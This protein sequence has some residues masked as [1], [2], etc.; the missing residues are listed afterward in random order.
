MRSNS[1]VS[2]CA[3]MSLGISCL[4]P[5]QWTGDSQQCGLCEEQLMLTQAF[6]CVPPR[7]RGAEA[8]L[9]DLQTVQGEGGGNGLRDVQVVFLLRR[10]K[11][12]V[13]NSRRRCL[14]EGRKVMS[15]HELFS[16]VQP[17]IHAYSTHTFCPGF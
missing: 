8:A 7:R 4:L 12:R 6:M 3:S 5:S 1:G 2:A 13:E 14:R 16:Q 9:E 17:C 15:S 10:Q 11:Q